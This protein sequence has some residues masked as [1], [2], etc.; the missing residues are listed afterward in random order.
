MRR[1]NRVNLTVRKLQSLKGSPTG[2][3]DYW[4]KKL[5]RF[6]VRVS[7][8]GRKTFTV[9]FRYNKKIERLKIGEFPLM[10]LAKARAEAQKALAELKS[11]D[12]PAA[13]GTFGELVT[14]YVVRHARP[15]KRESSLRN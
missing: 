11:G 4:D 5:P 15:N 3:I 8:A 12:N 9:L 1:P 10:S 7:P 2:Q 14:D 6:G 13:G